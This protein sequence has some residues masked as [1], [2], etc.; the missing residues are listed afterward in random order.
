MI[1]KLEKYLDLPV[2]FVEIRAATGRATTID[3][4]KSEVDRVISGSMDTFSVRV[5]DKGNFGFAATNDFKKLPQISERA[6]KLSKASAKRSMKTELSDEKTYVDSVK[7]KPKINPDDISLEEKT[8]DFL[9]LNKEMKIDKRI[10]GYE[11]SFL[12]GGFDWFYL[13]SEGSRINFSS[14]IS[15]MRFTSYAKEKTLQ[16]M[17][18]NYGGLYGYEI[19]NM[20]K[21][22][23]EETSKEALELLE[24]EL[25]PSGVYD[26][27]LDSWMTGVFSHE[28]LGH[29]CEADLVLTGESILGD[30][31]GKKIGSEFVS[32]YD[33]PT[34][35]R[36]FGSY[37]YDDEGVKAQK[38]YFLK[39]GVLKNFLQ[40]RETAT[41]MKTHS[42]GNARASSVFSFPI[43]RMSNV[44]FEPRDYSFDDLIDIEKGLYVIGMKGGQVDTSAG[45]Y[46]FAAEK[47]YL[48]ENGKL[49]KPIR[50]IILFGNILET[51][52]NVD[53]V[54]KKSE[55][56]HIG[57]C[58]KSGQ[59]LRVSDGG[60]NVRVR[61]VRVGGA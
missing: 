38:K 52:N 19:F 8:K 29:A 26:V 20:H 53:A 47:G 46:Q 30:K 37:P 61:S 1:D 55:M 49:T 54:G 41:K 24:A 35:K 57:F 18:N 56:N 43:V 34:M 28:A 9:K 42:T 7:I 40:S 17:T 27:V 12:E 15:N 13:N 2:D 23:A 48:I 21:N 14:N 5:L 59:S 51:L 22:E 36:N 4:K 58:G 32:I 6:V 25:V 39:D 31:M 45:N 50:D 11:T 16:S 60:P 3:V 44:I 10:I 33:D